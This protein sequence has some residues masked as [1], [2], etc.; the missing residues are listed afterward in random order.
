MLVKNSDFL[1]YNTLQN[2][3]MHENYVN[4]TLL[5]VRPKNFLIG[6]HIKITDI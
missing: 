1:F 6:Q 3:S 2:M 4:L 5:Y